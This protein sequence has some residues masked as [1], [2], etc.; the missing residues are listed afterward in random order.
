MAREEESGIRVTNPGVL[1]LVQDLG[2]FGYQHLG[3]SPGGAADEHAFLWANRLL[4]NPPGSAQLEICLGGLQLQVQVATRMAITGA[5]LQATLNG[6]ALTPWQTF[7]VTPGDRLHF[8]YPRGGVRGY[9]AVQGGFEVAPTF[10]S[11]STVMREKI[12]GLDGWGRPLAKGDFLLCAE[13]GG[14]SLRVPWRYVPDYDRP[15]VLKVIASDLSEAVGARLLKK[16]FQSAYQISAQSDRMGVRLSGET[17][18]PEQGG[19]VSEGLGFG[20]IQLPPDG[21]PIIMLKDRQTIGG[22]PK[23]GTVFPLD[24]FSLSQRQPHSTVTFA[25]ITL[26]EAQKRLARFYRFFWCLR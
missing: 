26:D 13:G 8:G 17:L 18:S 15:L 7:A 23:L 16:L 1:T 9:L 6:R 12:G 25:P 24:A 19:I 5:D 3:L 4:G 20:T 10:G 11:V 2:R 21:Q 14:P 22:Y